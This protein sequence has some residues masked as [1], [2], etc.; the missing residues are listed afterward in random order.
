MTYENVTKVF[1]GSADLL[2]ADGAEQVAIDFIISHPNY[3][4]SE[5][6][7]ITSRSH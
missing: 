2:G 5:K 3:T 7:D 6:N 1:L 4:P